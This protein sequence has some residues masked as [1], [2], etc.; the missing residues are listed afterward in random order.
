MIERQKRC[1][2]ILMCSLRQRQQDI[3]NEQ[4]QA[5]NHHGIFR[6]WLRQ[7]RRAHAQGLL[8]RAPCGGALGL[9]A[10]DATLHLV[11]KRLRRRH[12]EHG[13]RLRLGPALRPRALATARPTQDKCQATGHSAT[14]NTQTSSII[15]QS[16]P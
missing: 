4:G 6:G 10:R 9:V 7:Q 3:G 12:K 8:Q 1:G 13:T 14:P 5:I 2:C 11:V 15:S 16:A